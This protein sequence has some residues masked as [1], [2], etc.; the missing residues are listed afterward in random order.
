MTQHIA[1]A[2]VVKVSIGAAGG[3][4]V[5]AFVRRGD[6]VPE[7]VSR[8]QLERLVEQGF[9]EEFESPEPDAEPTVF[10]QADVDAAVKAAEDAKDAELESAREAV[11]AEA[12]KVAEARAE[13][14]AEAAKKVAPATKAPAAKQA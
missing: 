14:V 3:N 6:L 9:I 10:S 2:T 13:L 12:I 1:T 4:S 8:V 7:G 5:A 11:K